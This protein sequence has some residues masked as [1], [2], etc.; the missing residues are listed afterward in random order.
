MILPIRHVPTPFELTR[1][2]WE[3]TQE[4]LGRAKDYLDR[5][6]PDGY[7]VGWNVHEVGG[8][9]IP[10]A[11]LHVIGRYVDEPMAGQGI[12]YAMKQDANRRP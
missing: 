7:S 3:A 6:F 4:M 5:N 1:D 12:R 10:H 11:H 9:A 2:E 8:Q